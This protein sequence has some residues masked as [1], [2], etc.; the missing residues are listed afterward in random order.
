MPPRGLSDHDYCRAWCFDASGGSG[1]ARTQAAS[2]VRKRR[3]GPLLFQVS[4]SPGFFPDFPEIFVVLGLLVLPGL[5]APKVLTFLQNRAKLAIPPAEC[6]RAPLQIAARSAAVRTGG[7]S[8]RP[9]ASAGRLPSVR[10]PAREPPFGGCG[11][12]LRGICKMP[13]LPVL[14]A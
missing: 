10:D 11:H 8:D 12:M 3:L 2:S 7:L 6:P 9:E 1:Q 5:P 4:R 13:A 14:K